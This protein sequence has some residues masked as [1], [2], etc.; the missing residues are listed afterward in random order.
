MDKPPVCDYEGSDYQTTFWDS[1]GREYEDRCEA[2]AIRRLL[3]KKG[4]LLL[5]VGAGAGRN[6]LRYGGYERIVLLD[7]SLTQLQQ[8]HER[9]GESGRFLY[10]AA[11]V[12]QLPFVTGLFDSATMIRTLHHLANP[13]LALNEVRRVLRPGAF[14]LLEFANKLNLKSIFRFLLGRQSWSPFSLDPVEYLP[15]NFDFHPIRVREWLASSGFSILRLA[16]VSHFRI[17]WIKRAV[18]ARFLARLDFILGYTGG[19]L[20]LTPSVF[21]LARTNPV[22]SEMESGFFQC[23]LCQSSDLKEI[24]GTGNAYLKCGNCLRLFPIRGGIYDFKES[25]PA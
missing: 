4:R 5:E 1:G 24:G 8:A 12:Y 22:G 10:V 21:L 15:L 13:P 7:Y 11:N 6:T 14:F 9:L 23:P 17:G 2:L 18:P 25:F 16:T 19:F 3:P 20:Q